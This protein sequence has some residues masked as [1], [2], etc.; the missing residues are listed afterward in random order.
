MSWRRQPWTEWGSLSDKR[1]AFHVDKEAIVQVLH[2]EA[3]EQACVLCPAFTFERVRADVD[4]LPDTIR[5][6]Q[7]SPYEVRYAAAQSRPS[8]RDPA[9]G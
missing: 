9:Q 5:L 3:R 7:D 8:P 4:D 6:D 2:Q 1:D